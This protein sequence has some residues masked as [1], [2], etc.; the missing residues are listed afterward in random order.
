MPKIVDKYGFFKKL[1]EEFGEGAVIDRP[2]LLAWYDSKIVNDPMMPHHVAFSG[3]KQFRAD[4]GMYRVPSR[5][6]LETLQK[7]SKKP[8]SDPKPQSLQNVPVHQTVET[9]PEP[10]K[11][12]SAETLM[13][14]L[15]DEPED[16]NRMIDVETLDTPDDLIQYLPMMKRLKLREM[17]KK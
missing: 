2:Q 4:R 7:G 8:P 1:I 10:V 9:K 5:S 17:F 13:N 11:P 15:K 6:F 14:L 16:P 12:M 3:D